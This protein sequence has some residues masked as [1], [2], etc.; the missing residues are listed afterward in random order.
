[1]GLPL[2]YL[3]L[4]CAQLFSLKK[5]LSYFGYMTVCI[6]VHVH[7][8]GVWFYQMYLIIQSKDIYI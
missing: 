8:Y 1:M 4:S 7:T 6:H 5:E 2:Q 3:Y